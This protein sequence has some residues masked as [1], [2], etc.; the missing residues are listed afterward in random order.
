M[1]R[2]PISQCV[3]KHA[4]KRGFHDSIDRVAHTVEFGARGIEFQQRPQVFVGSHVALPRRS[5]DWW[6]YTDG[7]DHV[8]E[9]FFGGDRV[10][11]KLA[12]VKGCGVIAVG[13]DGTDHHLLGGGDASRGV[14]RLHVDDQIEGKVA[15]LKATPVGE[16]RGGGAHGVKGIKEEAH[17]GSGVL[18]GFGQCRRMVLIQSSSCHQQPQRRGE[19]DDG[20]CCWWRHGEEG[21]GKRWVLNTRVHTTWKKSEEPEAVVDCNYLRIGVV[22]NQ[23]ITKERC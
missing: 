15:H 12:G 18:A 22:V 8:V 11:Q 14:A 21:G 13:F 2:V 1:H 23:P 17:G 9:Q 20:R 3:D 4:F 10:A 19:Q 5:N 6:I 16:G 7:T